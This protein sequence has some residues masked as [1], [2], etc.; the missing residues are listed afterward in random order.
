MPNSKTCD[1]LYIENAN[2]IDIKGQDT[3]CLN[4]NQCFECMQPEIIRW[5][6]RC[7]LNGNFT[8]ISFPIKFQQH[9]N[10]FSFIS[11]AIYTGTQPKSSG[12]KLSENKSSYF[13]TNI[14]N[15]EREMCS[16]LNGLHWHLS[17]DFRGEFFRC[18]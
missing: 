10:R 2:G 12:C 16:Q 17:V 18:F 6:K 4:T 8:S 3:H 1:G 9:Q 11:N 14:L 7:D 5:I 15:R 13:G